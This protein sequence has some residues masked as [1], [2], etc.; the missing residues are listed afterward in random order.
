MLKLSVL[1]L[2]LEVL[3][4]GSLWR[5]ISSI[6]P[7]HKV[8]AKVTDVYQTISNLTSSYSLFKIVSSSSP[9]TY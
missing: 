4:C 1:V 8:I 2:Y 9:L 3:L 6:F 7:E 5:F